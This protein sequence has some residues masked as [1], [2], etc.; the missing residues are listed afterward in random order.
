MNWWRSIFK[1]NAEQ[2]AWDIRELAGKLKT[3]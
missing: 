3:F 1:P 2:Q